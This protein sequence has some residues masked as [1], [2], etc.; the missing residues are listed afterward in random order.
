MSG[1]FEVVDAPNGGYQVRLV[2]E[3]GEVIAVSVRYPSVQAAA[4]GI[5]STR[6]IAASG[7]IQ[8][9]SKRA[10]RDAGRETSS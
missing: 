7:L 4:E 3:S 8:D 1:H 10:T 9:H 2:S 6:E 5:D